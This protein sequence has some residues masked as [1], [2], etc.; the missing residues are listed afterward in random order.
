MTAAAIII[1]G[2]LIHA[3]SHTK[4]REKYGNGNFVQNKENK[5][6]AHHKGKQ[7]A[8]AKYIPINQSSSC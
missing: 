1:V 3:Y 6:D 8:R 7:T 5:I 4:K 2:P